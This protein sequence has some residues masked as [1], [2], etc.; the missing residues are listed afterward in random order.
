M[1][2]YY[3]LLYRLNQEPAKSQRALALALGISVGQVNY[4]LRFLVEQG[5]LKKGKI[6]YGLNER[7]QEI[8]ENM[9]E[10][11]RR[12]KLIFPPGRKDRVETAVILAAGENRNF[13]KPVGLLTIQGTAVIELLIRQMQGLGLSRF[14]V[15]VGAG[16]EAYREYFKGRNVTLVPNDRYKWTG[17]MA[18]LACVKDLVSE[19]F[20]LV[21]GNQI[22]E[23]RGFEKL[24]NSPKANGALLATPS[25]SG[26]EAY[27]ELDQEG[28]ILRISK[29][30][31]QMN[32]V[33]AELLGVSR[34]SAELFEKMMRYYEDN[35]NPYL[36]YEY[37]LETI[38]RIYQIP[39]IWAD[40]LAWTVIENE[41]LYRH[42]EHMVYPR[43]RNRERLGKENRAR[44]ALG[45]CLNIPPE[46]VEEVRIKGGM[47]NQNYYVAAQGKAYILRLP[48]ACTDTMIDR[49]REYTNTMAA[50]GLGLNP[51]VPYF[52]S[53]S[54]IKI[55][56]Y[57]PG[58]QTLN[59][60]SARLEMNMKL[61]AGL[62]KRLHESK[63]TMQ[64]TFDVFREYRAYKRLIEQ[65]G[66]S[67]YPGFDQMEAFL[68][69]LRKDLDCLGME[70]KPCH[71][72]LVAE[73][74]VRDR[75][76]RLYLIDWEYSGYNDPMWDL[77]SHMLECE[78]NEAEEE[79]FMQYYFEGR[80]GKAQ[81]QKIAAYKICQDLLWSAWTIAKEAAGEDFGTYGQDRFARAV[82]HRREYERTYG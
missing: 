73:N 44:E 16:E 49:E 62:L 37:V 18:S 38:G 3:D 20:L 19:D 17:T 42:A 27:V 7:G 68:E 55:S 78:F 79:L 8:L 67:W 66:A 56:S 82:E 76:G 36:N 22:L 39:G 50:A 34:I 61:T 32:R 80:I 26:D 4:M 33:D 46:Q 6:G 15:V 71:N 9:A 13:T 24:L 64:G 52:N 23:T 14:L 75:E 81:R 45:Q 47:T 5:Y 28:C 30:I 11:N 2:K 12:Q 25:G 21:E 48:G 51:P 72:D 35:E 57:I 10:E 74:L 63:I 54:G 58:A 41:K 65:Q 31:R 59:A 1:E 29:D 77:S 40:D 69:T 53:V 60:R 70:K 43:I